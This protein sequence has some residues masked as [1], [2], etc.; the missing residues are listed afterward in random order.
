MASQGQA[1]MR[2][3]YYQAAARLAHSL[4]ALQHLRE[5]SAALVRGVRASPW[6]LCLFGWLVGFAF[7][8]I[9]CGG[10]ILLATHVPLGI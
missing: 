8:A 2:G 9:M 6:L 10:P 3:R 7:A 4:G 1:R 5:L